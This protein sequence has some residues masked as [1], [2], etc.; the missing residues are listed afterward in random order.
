M[1]FLSSHQTILKRSWQ[2]V[3]FSAAVLC[4][5]AF[6]L[7]LGAVS[8][9]STAAFLFLIIVILSAYFGN[10]L[11][12]VITSITATLCFDYFY[13]P[14]V[15][16]LSITAFSDW[17]SLAIFLLTSV[18]ISRLTASASEKKAEATM[19]DGSL[20][21]LK[22]F[23]TLLASIPDSELTLTKIAGE[24]LRIFS[25]EYCSIHLYGK[26]KWH[27]FTGAAATSVIADKIKNQ[28]DLG[29]DHQADLTEIVDEN[30]L[31]VQYLKIDEDPVHQTMF[32][33]KTRVLSTNV[34]GAIA[35][36][37]DL[38]LMEFIKKGNSLIPSA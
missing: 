22:E 12:A 8:S 24:A 16:T 6:T 26:G 28:I 15:G 1:K 20:L 23:G 18:I 36:M 9:T 21:R 32:V 33:V 4:S 29:Q 37:I 35:S 14:P 27:H 25:L 17:I 19:L 13:L 7:K 11:V 2:I 30:M 5:T 3:V 31:E 38:R 10:I 34:I